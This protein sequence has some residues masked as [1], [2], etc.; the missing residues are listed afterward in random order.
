MKNKKSQNCGFPFYFPF[1]F[2]P[3]IFGHPPKKKKKKRQKSNTTTSRKK[4]ARQVADTQSQLL[5]AAAQFKGLSRIV[6]PQADKGTKQR[7][8]QRSRCGDLF[9][10]GA[11]GMYIGVLSIGVGSL[12][13]VP[14]LPVLSSF[15]KSHLWCG[16]YQN[17]GTPK[18]LAFLLLAISKMKRVHLQKR[19]LPHLP[20]WSCGLV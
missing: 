17:K 11:P 10:A 6:G 8:P 12:R 1:Y 9:G 2:A 4:R 3:L 20:Q 18:R 19:R 16:M 5:R 7:G 14:H 13:V 15:P